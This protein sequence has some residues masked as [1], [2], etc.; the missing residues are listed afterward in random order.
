MT[1]HPPLYIAVRHVA[2]DREAQLSRCKQL[3]TP[4]AQQKLVR[5][6][7]FAVRAVACKKANKAT[8]CSI[9]ATYTQ[10]NTLWNIQPPVAL[11]VRGRILTCSITCSAIIFIT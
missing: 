10:N 9:R 4:H 7:A 11:M 8:N 3:A 1:C 5:V 2:L 6:I